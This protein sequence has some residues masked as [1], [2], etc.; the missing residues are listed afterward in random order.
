MPGRG[1][2]GRLPGHHSL[3]GDLSFNASGT[4]LVSG[5]QN[6][7]LIRWATSPSIDALPDR[8]MVRL[9]LGTRTYSAAFSPDGTQL[10]VGAF[11]STQLW[12]LDTSSMVHDL[13]PVPA[14]GVESLAFSPDGTTVVAGGV[15]ADLIESTQ[16]YTNTRGSLMM[17]DTDSGRARAEPVSL[18][19]WVSEVAYSPDG[20]LVAVGGGGPFG[21]AKGGWVALFDAA[22]WELLRTLPAG[23]D[24][25]T[26]VAFG[27]GGS[28]LA[29]GTSRG[30]TWIWQVP[31]SDST[32]LRIHV[33][34][35]ADISAV[36]FS[37]DGE[38]VALGQE[39]G[40]EDEEYT[41]HFADPVTG[42][43]VG[44]PLE[45]HPG[46][47]VTGLAFNDDGSLL[48]SGGG[49]R[50][51]DPAGGADVGRRRTDPVDEPAA[52]GLGGGG[53]SV[54]GHQRRAEGGR[55]GPDGC[56]PLGPGCRLVATARLCHRGP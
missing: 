31:E 41:I 16:S 40:L 52:N 45:G 49:N 15:D 32:P 54:R 26:S 27:H 44:A 9:P 42:A 19:E 47:E 5:D 55:T 34:A 7:L 10:A 3:V 20:D 53:R 43:A 13:E 18:G 37:P 36:A 1:L 23:K 46:R 14:L 30:N 25:V 22:S 12:D 4:Q 11:E 28:V 21:A 35:D 38:L 50:S 6:G 29:A 51:G 48:V 39:V 33:D 56:S 24:T 17:W 2:P 8:A